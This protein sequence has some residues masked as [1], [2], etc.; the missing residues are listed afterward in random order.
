MDP[1][2][3]RNTGDNKKKVRRDQLRTFAFKTPKEYTVSDPQQRWGQRKRGGKQTRKGLNI[4]LQQIL[5]IKVDP[6]F[7]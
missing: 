5:F 1:L 6:I 4:K 7:F 3:K 2:R